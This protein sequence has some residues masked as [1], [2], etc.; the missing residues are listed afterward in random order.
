MGHFVIRNLLSIMALWLL[1]I[2]HLGVHPQLTA[3]QEHQLEQY[4]QFEQRQLPSPDQS[5]WTTSYWDLGQNIKIDQI[6]VHLG[7]ND[8]RLDALD[9]PNDGAIVKIKGDQREME[10]RE[11]VWFSIL[12][13]GVLGALGLAGVNFLKL[14]G[15]P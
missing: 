5:P 12:S 4:Q 8:H 9:G 14:K 15:M 7:A 10:G 11:G 3:Q 1:S 6:N 13:A 2:T